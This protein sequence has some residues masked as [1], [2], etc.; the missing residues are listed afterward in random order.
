MKSLL[1]YTFCLV[2]FG[3]LLSGCSRKKDSFVSRN[4]HAVTTEYN[5]LYNGGVALDKGRASLVE[6]FNDNY[7]EVLPIERIVFTENTASGEENRDPNFLKAEE[8]AIKA[9]QRHAMKIDGEERN[10]QIDEA[11]LLLGKARYYDQ[12]FVPALEAFNYILAYYPKSNNIAQAKVW[13]EKTNIRLENNV[14]AIDNLKD[15]F[16]VESEL[17]NQDRADAHAML[18]QAFLNLETPDSALVYIK[19]ASKLTKKLEERGR[20]NFIKGQLYNKLGKTDS[21]NLA[22]QEVIDLNRKVPRKYHIN[23]HLE[24]IRNFDY[25]SGDTLLLR[26]RLDLLVKNRENRPF[27]DKIY[28]TKATYFMNIGKEDSAIVN[29]NKSLLQ[30]SSDQFLNSRDY[31]ALADYNF[32]KAAYKTAGAYYDSVLNK[33]PVRTREYRSI[34]KKRENLNDVIGYENTAIRNDSIIRLITMPEEELTAYFEAYISK[35]KEKATQDSLARVEEVRNQEFFTNSTSS[36][37]QGAAG[38][39]EFYFYNDVAVAYGKQSFEKQWGN[40]RLEDRWRTS[41]KQNTLQGANT[42]PGIAT[43]IVEEQIEAKTAADYIATL[44]RERTQIDSLIKERN[45]AYFQLGLIYKEKFKEF[46]LAIERLE[47]L[48]TFE[49]DEKLILPAKYNLYQLYGNTDA[50]AKEDSLKNDILTTYPNSRY[51]QR[52][53]NPNTVFAADVDAPEEVYKRLYDRFKAEEFETLLTVLDT[54]IE[55]FYGDPYLPKF[56]LLK[57]TA[58]GRYKGYEAYKTALNFVALTYP[59]TEEG[60]KA[61]SLLQKVLPNMAFSSFDDE[62]LSVSY[63]VLFPFENKDLVAAQEFNKKLQEALEKVKYDNFTISLDSYSPEQSFVVVHY[64]SSRSQAEG[65]VELLA[66]NDEI[67]LSRDNIIIA[68]E[69]YKIVQLHKNV[70]D[71]QEKITN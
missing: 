10:P 62:A 11:F 36:R 14:I 69:N 7:W 34:R 30:K 32:D 24:K 43:T 44:P 8:K 17:S 22:F 45:V 12:Q 54:R 33:L 18:A 27:L 25:A 42:L 41:T 48:I 47:K 58:L 13:K 23:A 31:L 65:L 59:R 50:F 53:N 9:I 70:E 35:I 19:S 29:Y 2:L 55:Q 61:Q 64:L 38:V 66:N 16:E 57:A 63:K 52:I 20:Y 46:P 3:V 60:K 39:G 67:K 5:T 28:Y 1:Y 49:P 4:F 21:A 56:E 68:S 40:R 6:T 37:K 26:E 15:I 51:A 71:Y